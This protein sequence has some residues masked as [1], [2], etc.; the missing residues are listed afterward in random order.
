MRMVPA[1][2][3]EPA[4]H[5]SEAGQAAQRSSTTANQPWPSGA[6]TADYRMSQTEFSPVLPA[7]LPHLALTQAVWLVVGILAAE[8]LLSVEEPVLGG[9][10]EQLVLSEIPAGA[11]PALPFSA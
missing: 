8:V 4:V 10:E 1:S 5:R 9:T 7:H 11:V 3:A 6:Q 2:A